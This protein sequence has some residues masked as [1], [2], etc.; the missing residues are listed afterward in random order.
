MC[1]NAQESFCTSTVVEDD[2][3]DCDFSSLP[4]LQLELRELFTY[5]DGTFQLVVEPEALKDM[6][7]DL[8]TMQSLLD[9]ADKYY[10]TTLNW[11]FWVAV[12]CNVTLAVIALCIC[13]AV[14]LLYFGY[15]LSPALRCLRSFVLIPC[16]LI[17]VVLGWAFSTAFIVSS[18][19]IAD[20]CI[21]SPDAAMLT[22]LNRLEDDF[23][24]NSVMHDFLEYFVSGCP[25][26]TAPQ[27]LDQQI[28]IMT[29]I[30]VP[31]LQ[32]LL[33]TMEQTGFVNL[34]QI[35]G[36]DLTPF[37]A[38]IDAMETQLCELSQSIVDLRVLLLCPSWYAMYQYTVH[39]GVCYYSSTGFGWA[40]S[41]QMVLVVLSMVILTL[42]VS[43]YQLNEVADEGSRRCVTKW[44]CCVETIDDDDEEE[45][46]DS[47]GEED[48]EGGEHD[49]S[50]FCEES[51]SDQS[52]YVEEEV[53]SESER[54]KSNT[55]GHDRD[56]TAPRDKQNNQ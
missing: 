51:V 43:Y 2:T 54:S 52:S 53:A 19:G 25:V 7:D 24:E 50:Q 49:E 40:A 28:V 30:I 32:Q 10:P 21:N 44:C 33:S 42:R 37:S 6:Q 9:Q 11:T 8:Q 55:S 23:L 31:T 18:L 4:Q 26:E 48:G 35:C 14:M 38:I 15:P 22:I 41:T 47:D 12:V 56:E 3:R 5:L 27:G 1:P 29:Q 46:T 45:I 16:F 20:T 34:Q 13:F 39:N 36:V 17:F